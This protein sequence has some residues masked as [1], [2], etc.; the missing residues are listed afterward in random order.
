MRQAGFKIVVNLSNPPIKD[1]VGAL[2]ARICN[3]KGERFYFVNLKACPSHLETLEKQVYDTNGMPD[4]SA[5]LDHSGDA[6]GYT[7]IKRHPVIKSSV[8]Y[9][10]G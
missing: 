4:K 6:G 8:G 10:R 7:A 9:L 2:N 1:R 5:G 3:G